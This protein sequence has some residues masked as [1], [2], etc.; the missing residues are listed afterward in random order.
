MDVKETD[1]GLQTHAKLRTEIE[2]I[3]GAEG[4]GRGSVEGFDMSPF[5]TN[6]IEDQSM[7]AA[8]VAATRA[9]PRFERMTQVAHGERL[10]GVRT[11]V[12]SRELLKRVV[13]DNGAQPGQIFVQGIE[14]PVPVAAAVDLKPLMRREAIVGHDVIA[15]A[16]LGRQI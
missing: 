8:G 2:K 10:R 13:P 5:E 16:H 3:L 7:P 4:L 11:K 12:S 14:D 15:R 6:H 1:V 9:Q